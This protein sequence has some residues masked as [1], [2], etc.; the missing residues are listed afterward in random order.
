MTRTIFA[1]WSLDFQLVS[2]FCCECEQ[3]PI[4]YKYFLVVKGGWEGKQT[5]EKRKEKDDEATLGEWRLG[6][7]TLGSNTM[8]N[9]EWVYLYWLS[10]ELEDEIT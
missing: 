1:F 9:Y 10:K 8:L 7:I 5:K 4:T 3:C 6:K 2:I